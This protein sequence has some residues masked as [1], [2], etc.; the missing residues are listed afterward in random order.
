VA[1]VN[2]DT[3]VESLFDATGRVSPVELYLL[4]GA[5]CWTLIQALT[6]P[7]ERRQDRSW[8]IL[9]AWNVAVF[10]ILIGRVLQWTATSIAP[11]TFGVR[12]QVFSALGI[13]VVSLLGVARITKVDVR[14]R[15]ALF[16][17]G[18]FGCVT[19]FTTWVVSEAPTRVVT[20]FQTTFPTLEKGP[21]WPIAMMVT[22]GL[23]A[24]SF[25]LMRRHFGG[26]PAQIWVQLALVG[27]IAGFVND[28]LLASHRITST[29]FVHFPITVL[30]FLMVHVIERRAALE[31][32]NLVTALGDDASRF[33]SLSEV[34]FEGIL[35]HANGLITGANP[36]AQRMFG[37]GERDLIGTLVFAKVEGVGPKELKELVNQPEQVLETRGFRSDGSTFPMQLRARSVV[38][39]EGRLNVLVVRDT[40]EETRLRARVLMTD[41]LASLGTLA[42]GA[43]HEI[44]NPLQYVQGN[45]RLVI[46]LLEGEVSIEE[47]R[48][49]SAISSLEEAAEGCDRVAGIVRDLRAL[50]RGDDEIPRAIDIREALESAIRTT[51]HEVRLR[52]ML[53]RE[54]DDV[55]AVVGIRNRLIQVFVNLIINA[56]HALPDGAMKT[57]RITARL[58]RDGETVIAEIEDTGAGIPPALRERMFDPFF[59]ARAAD[60]GMG[61]GLSISHNLLRSM[62]ATIEY[63]DGSTGGALF[64][65]ALQASKVPV[66]RPAKTFKRRTGEHPGRSVLVVDDEVSVGKLFPRMLEGYDVDVVDSGRAAIEACM[67]KDYDVILCDVTMPDVSGMDVYAALVADR[68]HLAERMIFVTG[69]GAGERAIA[70][71]E[72]HADRRIDKPVSREVLRKIVKRMVGDRE[73]ASR[74]SSSDLEFE[75]D[76]SS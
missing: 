64:R 52:A 43:A 73:R 20:I 65:V 14:P 69:G 46:Q 33:R 22:V 16:L 21:L 68:K 12:L 62:G 54:F 6:G 26:G 55:P 51:A 47:S 25:A 3:N 70:F 53:V 60:Q 42:A 37:E 40:T 66:T 45:V 28:A 75:G 50:S 74:P 56:A 63:R 58:K 1:F 48:R 59:S 7:K 31:R 41:R 13:A 76:R 29:P 2:P 57:Q 17:L 9:I 34:A 8:P 36:A 5:V 61:L 39:D 71:L 27:T 4:L 32:A 44:N 38:T 49:A 19:F 30:G 11:L 24:G 72:T 10:L 18:V 35:V 15:L 67:R 23:G